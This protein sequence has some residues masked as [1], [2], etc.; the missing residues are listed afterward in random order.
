LTTGV[1]LENGK[2]LEVRLNSRKQDFCDLEVSVGE[3]GK[4]CRLFDANFE[5]K[6]RFNYAA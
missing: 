3:V 1:L 4:K 2:A 5:K 6:G